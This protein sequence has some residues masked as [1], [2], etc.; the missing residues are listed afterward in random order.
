M[1]TAV[2]VAGALDALAAG[3]AAVRDAPWLRADAVGQGAGLARLESLRRQLDYAGLVAVRD[4][5]A[6]GAR[7]VVG[8]PSMVA[9][10]QAR[11]RLSPAEAAARMRAVA[12]MCDGVAWTG[13]PGPG[14]P[15]RRPPP[16][17][18]PG[19]VGPEHVRIIVGAMGDLPADLQ[20]AVRCSAEARL[21]AD[22]GVFGPA[23]LRRIATRLTHH[24]A[25][26]EPRPQDV[27]ARRGLVLSTRT[28]NRSANHIHHPHH[29]LPLRT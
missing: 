19:V 23:E 5:E 28:R 11:L 17:R 1:G 18:R 7:A 2:P 27:A 8:A 16:R 4:L 13:E 9:L 24:L 10:L 3:V 21:V 25:A 14:P 20:P 29:N 12:G 6:A 15:C 22:A 26:E